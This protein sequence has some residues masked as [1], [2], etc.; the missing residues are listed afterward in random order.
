MGLAIIIVIVVVMFV[1]GTLMPSSH[2]ITF[3]RSQVFSTH[4][5]EGIIYHLRDFIHQPTQPK[6]E[7]FLVQIAGKGRICLPAGD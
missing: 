4:R 3:R 6:I 5:N 1:V 7:S 2:G